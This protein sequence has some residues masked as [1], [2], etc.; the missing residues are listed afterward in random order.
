[1][2]ADPF[3]EISSADELDDVW[4]AQYVECVGCVDLVPVKDGTDP[5]AYGLE[6]I[7]LKPWHRRFRVVAL[8]NFS[9]P[10]PGGPPPS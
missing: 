3:P 4:T 9:V 6:H 1:M 8:T 7:R 2:T 10:K 5:V